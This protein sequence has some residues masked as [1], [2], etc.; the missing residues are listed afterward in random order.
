MAV[1]RFTRPGAYAL[2]TSG[3]H[4]V[5]VTTGQGPYKGMWNL[6]GGGIEFGETPEEALRRELEE[7]TGLVDLPD[8]ELVDSLSQT[9]THPLQP[10]T[11]MHLLGF[12]FRVELATRVPVKSVPDGNDSLG[13]SWIQR[14]DIASLTIGRFA[15]RGVD[16][17]LLERTGK[18]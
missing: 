17:W 1:T 2:V 3:D 10:D 7:E 4:I 18:E 15:R 14:D 13:A 16:R 5:L 11:E 12:L 6:P 8:P 9:E